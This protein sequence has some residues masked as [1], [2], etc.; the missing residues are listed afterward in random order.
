MKGVS[1]HT[2][3]AFLA[4]C[5]STQHWKKALLLLSVPCCLL[6]NLLNPNRR[7]NLVFHINN[8]SKKE[9]WNSKENNGW[10]M[11]LLISPQWLT[12][13][14]S[15][16]WLSTLLCHY[17]LAMTFHVISAPLVNLGQL[18]WWDSLPVFCAPPLWQSMDFSS[19]STENKWA[20]LTSFLS[21]HY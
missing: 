3:C 6:L 1:V 4:E 19:V 5:Q 7:V 16:P 21:E 9:R 2:R 10:T 18:S 12:S 13:A 20:L 15:Q 8:S 11:Q 14:T 17:P